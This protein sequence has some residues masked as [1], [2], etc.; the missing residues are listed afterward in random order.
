MSSLIGGWAQPP[1]STASIC[2]I[3][4]HGSSV[5][6]LNSIGFC[7]YLMWIW[8]TPTPPK[9]YEGRKTPEFPLIS[10]G[11]GVV[12]NSSFSEIHPGSTAPPERGS[13]DESWGPNFWQPEP[14]FL[15]PQGDKKRWKWGLSALRSPNR[16]KRG[17]FAFL[18]SFCDMLSLLCIWSTKSSKMDD[19][20]VLSRVSKKCICRLHCAQTNQKT[21]RTYVSQ[22]T[23]WPPLSIA[24]SMSN[25]MLE[26]S[27]K[28]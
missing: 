8:A 3:W 9:N 22:N 21:K 15:T 5:P 17:V 4:C 28:P 16:L 26:N 1:P 6:P 27:L 10:I 20:L 23:R 12:H 18:V 24:N 7:V 19:F 25:A 14:T 11:K 2:N 13:A